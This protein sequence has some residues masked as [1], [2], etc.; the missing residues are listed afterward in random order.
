VN[1]NIMSD[2]DCNSTVC[3]GFYRGIAKVGWKGNQ[4]GEKMFAV[5]VIMPHDTSGSN[6]ND[7][8]AIW[9][10]NGQI[11]RTAQWGCN[12]RGMGPIGGCGELDVSEVIPG[13]SSDECTSTLYSFDKSLGC[14][15]HFVRPDSAPV[16]YVI[17]FDASGTGS[18]SIIEQDDSFSY[19]SNYAQAE[20]SQWISDIG[21]SVVA[22]EYPYTAEDECSG[23]S[24]VTA[25]QTTKGATSNVEVWVGIVVGVVV[26]LIVI[27]VIVVIVV[28]K[29]K[30]QSEIV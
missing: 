13:R 3:P 18:V 14:N 16:T 20:V 26:F 19:A 25:G 17:V 28:M 21:P 5:T 4:C 24:A 27:V 2:V 9:F 12:C 10:L 15:D 8:P 11:V 6:N 30:R 22:L 29:T 23:I 7:M 1:V